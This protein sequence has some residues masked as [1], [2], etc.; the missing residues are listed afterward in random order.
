[1]RA[2]KP[3][4]HDAITLKRCCRTKWLFGTSASIDI[5]GLEF[6]ATLV[7]GK[8]MTNAADVGHPVRC[9]WEAWTPRD[10]YR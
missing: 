7:K 8:H 9:L 10:A 1:M 4:F 2:Y 5:F 3:D 6:V